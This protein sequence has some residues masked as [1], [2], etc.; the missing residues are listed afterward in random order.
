VEAGQKVTPCR[1]HFVAMLLPV[2]TRFRE[3][4]KRDEKPA[5]GL[6]VPETR[7]L[8]LQEKQEIV[9]QN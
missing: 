9:L 7:S 1:E 8:S 6:V 2:A 3:R 4:A 5:N